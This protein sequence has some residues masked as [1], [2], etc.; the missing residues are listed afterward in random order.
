MKLL[1]NLVYAHDAK[2]YEETNQNFFNYSKVQKYKN[3]V[4]YFEEKNY[5]KLA[6]RGPNAFDLMN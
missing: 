2:G 3:C 6:N 5:V 1:R 4:Q